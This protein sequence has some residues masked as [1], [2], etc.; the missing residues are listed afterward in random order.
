MYPL[1]PDEQVVDAA[2]RPT[3]AFEVDVCPAVYS[4]DEARPRRSPADR[5][6]R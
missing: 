3:P 2:S 1:A 6:V 4:T 5:A